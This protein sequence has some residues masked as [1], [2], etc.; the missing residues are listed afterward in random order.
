MRCAWLMLAA[1][2][3]PQPDMVRGDGAERVPLALSGG[4]QNACFSPDGSQLLFTHWLGG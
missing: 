1:C 2:A 4:V 3:A